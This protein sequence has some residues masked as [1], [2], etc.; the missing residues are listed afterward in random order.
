MNKEILVRAIKTAFAAIASIVVC[1][2]LKLDYASAAGIIAILNVFE[3]RRA[4]FSG[5][6]K[7][8]ISAIIAL[9]IGCISFEL[10]GY[11]TW[12]FG[13]YLLIF[14]PI[15]F[16][17]K[18][19]L[20]LGPS[21]VLVT[22]ILAFGTISKAIVFNEL[23]LVFIGTG[24]AFL[25]NLY[26][27]NSLNSLRDLV[28]EIDRDMAY[29]LDL[30]GRSLKTN[31]D[32]ED[33]K[34]RLFN[35]E[36]KINLALKMGATETGNLIHDS[37][38]IFYGIKLRDRQYAILKEIFDDLNSIDPAFSEGTI[39]SDLLIDAGARISTNNDL[40]Q[41]KRNI[42]DFRAD[43]KNVD[44]PKSHEDFAIRASIFQVFSSLEEFVDISK[45]IA[46][47]TYD[48]GN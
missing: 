20:G 37:D 29:L 6:V 10:L 46:S 23:A 39:V 2:L 11:N 31:M 13:I 25:T 24:F 18:I 7:R 26:A 44:L 36:K 21:S 14:V 16:F 40:D 12:V 5:G 28:E 22:H 43:L 42:L 38:S 19:E 30:C 27:P 1:N 8:T 9:I 3:T 4:T 32:L 34:T 45:L 48:I 17:L 35:L 47:K 15:S 41:V 33:F